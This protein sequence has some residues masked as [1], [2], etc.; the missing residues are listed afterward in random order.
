MDALLDTLNDEL[1]QVNTRIGRIARW[2]AMGGFT[3]S[4]SPSPSPQASKD[5]DDFDGFGDDDGDEDEDDDANSSRNKEMTASQWLT[6]CH[7][8]KKWGVVLGIKV[9]MYLEGELV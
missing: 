5:E 7:L 2:Q 6:L 8:W 9:V 4:L 1:C 3:A